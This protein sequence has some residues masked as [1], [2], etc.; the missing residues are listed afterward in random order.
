MSTDVLQESLTTALRTAG[1]TA[2]RARL[3]ISEAGIT[4]RDFWLPAM[5]RA[6]LRSA[7]TYEGKRLIP[8]DPVGVYYAWH[9]RRVRRRYAIYLVAARREMID[10]LLAAVSAAGLQIDRID[11][12]PL[13]LAR[14]A[15]ASDGLILDWG[16]GEATL[17][18]MAKARPRFFRSVLLDT[19]EGDTRAQFDE[20]LL[21][22][23][24]LIKFIRSAEPN[25]QLDS[26]TPLYL[27]GRFAFLPGAEAMAQLRFPF[28]VRWPRKPRGCAP[29]FPWQAHLTGIG[30]LRRSAWENRITP[31]A[32]G[33]LRAAA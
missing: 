12:K 20:L 23:N 29:G 16:M 21:S 19:P 15:A 2:R 8:I 30:L 27:S 32:G 25:I 14:G 7:I 9:V 22:F 13:A 1:V 24:A 17:V 31:S 6:E 28:A 26:L 33:E 4:V 5:P 18:L 11:L 3:A 10:G